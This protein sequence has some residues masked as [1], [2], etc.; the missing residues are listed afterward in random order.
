MNEI[1]ASNVRQLREQ[2]GWSQEHLAQA[3]GINVRPLQRV[4]GGRGASKETLLALASVFEVFVEELR[5]DQ[6]QVLAQLFGV[7]PHEITP[8]LVEKKIEEVKAKYMTV[9]LSI[10]K[11][12]ADLPTLSADGLFFEC[13]A[14]DEAV[15]D[16]AAELNEYIQEL[17]DILDEREPVQQ[18]KYAKATFEI[19][20]QLNGLGAAVSIGIH[21]HALRVANAKAIHWRTLYVLVAPAAEAKTFAIVEK[22]APMLFR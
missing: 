16:V 17:F 18:R 3:A 20:Q 6:N 12:V 19:I 1:I 7:E 8:E 5:V 11:A 15:Q 21:R 10:V 14:R 22:N 9:P 13:L 2:R 4:E